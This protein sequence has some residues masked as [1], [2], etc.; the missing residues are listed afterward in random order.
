MTNPATDLVVQ[1]LITND[2]FKM[3]LETVTINHSAFTAPFRFVRNYVPGGSVTATLEDLSVVTFQYLPMVIQK[4]SQDGNLNQTWKLVLQDLNTD[5]Q[6]A[7]QAIPLD[8][9]ELPVIEVRTFEYDKR[10]A[11]VTLIEGPYITNSVGIDYDNVGAAINAEANRVNISGT[12]FK[13]TPQRFPTL[14]PLMR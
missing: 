5:I 2:A 14:R 13:M 4:A 3:L 11:A 10:T 1:A 7:E 8:S 6:A 12:G 9:D